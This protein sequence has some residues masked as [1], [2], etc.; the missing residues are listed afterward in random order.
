MLAKVRNGV[1][2][3]VFEEKPKGVANRLNVGCE[4]DK[5]RGIVDTIELNCDQWI[6]ARKDSF[7]LTEMRHGGG[8]SH[9]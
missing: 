8:G 4:K 9:F 1:I 6:L 3:G 7:P 5:P 2:L